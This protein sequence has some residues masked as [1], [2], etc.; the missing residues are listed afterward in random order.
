MLVHPTIV[1]SFMELCATTII[2]PEIY[3]QEFA[4]ED[5]T[6]EEDAFATSLND[7]NFL[8]NELE[9]TTDPLQVL[10]I[11][12]KHIRFVAIEGAKNAKKFQKREVILS[13]YITK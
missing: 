8:K 7:Y 6:L 10:H 3:K 11:L 12:E 9:K 1:N 2:D 5:F 4:V 13:G